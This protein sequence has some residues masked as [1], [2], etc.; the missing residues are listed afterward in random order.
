MTNAPTGYRC[1]SVTWKRSRV[2]HLAL[3]KLDRVFARHVLMKEWLTVVVTLLW[4]SVFAATQRA[5]S[6]AR[7]HIVARD[8]LGCLHERVLRIEHVERPRDD[9]FGRRWWWRSCQCE[10]HVSSRL[11]VMLHFA[12]NE[13]A[14]QVTC[15]RIPLARLAQ[16]S[17]SNPSLQIRCCACLGLSPCI[18]E[19]ANAKVMFVVYRS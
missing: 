18:H 4:H 13:V 15:V 3:E 6:V 17:S 5:L 10:W 11:C 2:T 14:H 7:A 8:S 1:A 16:E 12:V 9:S 19:S